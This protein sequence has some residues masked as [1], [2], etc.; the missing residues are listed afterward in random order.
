M[1]RLLAALLAAL[2]CATGISLA[3]AAARIQPHF[4]ENKLY[5]IY[6]PADWRVR[7]TSRPDSLRVQ[8]SSPDGASAVDFFWAPNAETRFDALRFL[9]AYRQLL[10]QSYPDVT[11]SSV[12]A[13]RDSTRAVATVRMRAG[14]VPV[15]GRYY[16]EATATRL[17]AQG[18]SAPEARFA[19]ER[20]LLLNVLASFAFS[21]AKPTPV[22][23]GRTVLEP[24]L[25]IPLVTKR[26]QD[27]SFAMQV[28]DDWTFLGGGGKVVTFAQ[29][30]GAGFIFTSF[31]GNPV[32][33]GASVQQGVIGTPYQPPARALET[34]L[35]G[36][37]HRNVRIRSA[38]P[39]GATNQQFAAMMRR[40]CDAQ[41]IVV[42]W[43]SNTGQECLGGFKMINA[44]PS[45]VGQWYV[46]MAGAWG[47]D[48]DLYRYLPTL[49]RVASS[50]SINDQYARQYI[51]AGLENLRRLQAQ[52]QAAMQDLN[53]AREQNQAD[54]EAR[55]ARKDFMDSKWDDYRRGNSYWVSDLE[56]GKV[57][58]TDPWGT[59]DTAT[60]D[61]WEGRG[62]NWTNFEGQNPNHPSENMREVSSYELQHLGQQRR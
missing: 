50:F 6:K 40:Q 42:N 46:I 5:A 35:V 39:D 52:T 26:A 11:L 57:Y 27:G 32:L 47:P 12:Y 33:R 15:T 19:S 48:R 10:T 24:P 18:Y 55:Q 30:G 23:G 25:Q 54:W 62:Y 37:G 28:P 7:E 45:V 36:L 3:Q 14:A 16:F 2:P 41:D 29:G 22:A 60:G 34:I 9:A 53:R 44:I 59:R 51:Q 4:A 31:S 43:T 61:Y 13:S 21:K 20:P 56:G 38:R 49:E 8:V 17:S 58:H 1:P